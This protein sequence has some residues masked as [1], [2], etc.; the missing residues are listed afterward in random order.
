MIY[1][2]SRISNPFFGKKSHTVLSRRMNAAGINVIE[3]FRLTLLSIGAHQRSFGPL[4][5]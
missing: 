4:Q 3:L 2:F 1:F 5:R